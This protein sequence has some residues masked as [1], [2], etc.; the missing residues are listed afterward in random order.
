MDPNPIPT[1]LRAAFEARDHDATLEALAPDVVLRSP[2]FELPFTGI[3]EAG[4]LFAVLIEELWPLTYVDEIPGDPHVLHFT[5]EINGKELE[6][7]DL[8]RFDE[9]GRVKEITVFFRPFPAVAAFLSKT[10]PKLARKRG[11]AGRAA[12]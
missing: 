1:P 8:L 3:D 10:G 12:F 6:G 9:E 4:D 5:G 7:L 11:G 2:I